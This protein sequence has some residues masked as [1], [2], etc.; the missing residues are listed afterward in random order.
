MPPWA[1]AKNPNH[2]PHR[3]VFGRM[4]DTGEAAESAKNL[5]RCKACSEFG[6]RLS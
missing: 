6:G 1:G 4:K 2:H 5:L 3:M